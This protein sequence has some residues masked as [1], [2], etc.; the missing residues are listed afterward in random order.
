MVELLL[1]LGGF[2]SNAEKLLASLPYRLGKK[3]NNVAKERAV[4]PNR[5]V[6]TR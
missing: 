4:R 3:Y 6:K 5:A 1:L 2:T